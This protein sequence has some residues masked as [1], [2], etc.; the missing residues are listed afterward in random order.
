[1]RCIKARTDCHITPRLKAKRSSKLSVQEEGQPQNL[2]AEGSEFEI[3]FSELYRDAATPSDTT[4]DEINVENEA[5]FDFEAA[6]SDFTRSI[7]TC[8]R[9]NNRND[10]DEIME[11]AQEEDIL[12]FDWPESN[13]FQTNGY[14]S[15]ANPENLAPSMGDMSPDIASRW[16]DF[17][18]T[19]DLKSTHQASESKRD[20]DTLLQESG[21][22]ISHSSIN[23]G[24]QT[25]SFQ[26][27]QT[28]SHACIWINI[29]TELNLRLYTL[30]KSLSHPTNPTDGATRLGNTE[31]SSTHR[32]RLIDEAFALS[33]RLLDLY[34]H[35][36][37]KMFVPEVSLP[38]P[39]RTQSLEETQNFIFNSPKPNTKD[40]KLSVPKDPASLLLLISCRLR[41]IEVY[42]NILLQT[43]QYISRR[44]FISSESPERFLFME[45]GVFSTRPSSDLR[46]IYNLQLMEYFFDHIL[47]RSERVVDPS[48]SVVMVAHNSISKKEAEILNVIKELQRMLNE[49]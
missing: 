23:S 21:Y 5:A 35:L 41:A 7:G 12:S 24:Y 11:L 6:F 38:K 26:N 31:I 18:S 13:E 27:Q 10:E 17:L 29:V 8:G 3:A 36:H 22:G 28:N 20:M 40:Q 1:M 4:E 9:D 39:A 47:K 15:S 19:M 25:R 32:D 42:Q 14:C 2:N 45:T 16:A 48:M 37:P 34:F 44:A 43:W 49:T 33:Q 30:Q 46:V